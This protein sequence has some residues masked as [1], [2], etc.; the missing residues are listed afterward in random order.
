MVVV[1]SGSVTINGRQPVREA[2][3]VLFER[4]GGS[5]TI[6]AGE[7]AI[8]LALTGQPINESVA[9]HGPFVMNSEAEIERAIAD[10]ESGRFGAINADA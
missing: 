7:N 1:L 9:W 8:V 5:V 4:D 6:D 2:E 3:M 10:F